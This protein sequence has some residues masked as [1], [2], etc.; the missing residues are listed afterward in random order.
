MSD[1]HR[2]AKGGLSAIKL[3]ALLRQVGA[4]RYHHR[5]PFHQKMISGALSKTEMQAWALNRFCYQA[6]IPRK[7]AMILARAE[8]PA[9]RAAWRRRIEDHDGAD[10]WSGGIKRWLHLATS[11]GLDADVVK[12]E[13][14]ALP[15]T[16][17]AVGAYLSF[18]TNRTLMEAV[19][20][21]LTEMFSPAIIGERVPAMLAK[22]DYVTEDTL[23]YFTRRPEQATRDADFALAYVLKHATTPERQ[24]QVVDAL[25]F[26]C[27]LL[28]AMLDALQ[29]AYGEKTNIPPGA[30]CLE[31]SP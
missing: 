3:E 29:H 1:F 20:S 2:A 31:L 27:D 16:R 21:S 22:Y 30:F 11:L 15:A 23:A 5:H 14:L 10:G 24:Q 4:E 7:D 25:V 19:A 6:V 26:K 17:F 12:S 18:C 13:R 9:F 8:D 28:W